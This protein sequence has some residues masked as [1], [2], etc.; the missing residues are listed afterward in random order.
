MTPQKI[1]FGDNQ[2]FGV[3]HMSEE[4]ARSQSMK[5]RDT[6]SI[7][8]VLDD[9]YDAGIKV[10]MCTTYDR[11]GEIAEIVKN[12]PQRY[13]DFE[14]YPCMPYAHKY[15]NSV[16]EV[17][18]I[19]TLKNFSP[20]GVMDTL[21]RGAVSVVTEDISKMMQL[22]V[23]TEM[24]KFEGVKTPIIFLQNVVTDLL[25]G[26]KF[27]DMLG[28]YHKYIQNKFGAEAGF[29]T[30]NLPL[31]LRVLDEQGIKNPIVCANINKIGFR[32]CGGIEEYKKVI[33][34]GN[35]RVI[36]MSVLASGAIPPKEAIE[37]VCDIEGLDS[38]V[39]GASSAANI[40]NTKSLI[41]ELWNI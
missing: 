22:L 32:M 17:G 20:S 12:N 11:V 26:L 23:D 37:W 38:I 21:V 39:F 6:A 3:N 36:A 41:D 34:Q 14:F 5:F 13:P 4:K 1:L 7:M 8:H 19:K 9:A 30:M 29:I 2:F 31:L 10:F 33:A 28:E 35:S 40:N 16:G 27:Y 18:I 25:L 15:A 24:K